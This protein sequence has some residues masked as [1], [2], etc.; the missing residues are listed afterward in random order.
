[1]NI[2]G[3]GHIAA[4][5]YNE[6][7]SVSGSGRID[8]SVR[9]VALSCS[10]SVR[11]EGDIACSEDVR[12]SGSSYF[13]KS[14]SA[15]DVLVSGSVSVDGDITVEKELRVSGGLKC[16]GSIKCSIMRCSGGIDVGKEA[17]ADEIRISGRITC[18]GLLNAEKIDISLDGVGSSSRIGSIGGSEI[19]VRN[20]RKGSCSPRMPL[21]SKLVGIGGGVLSVDELVEGDIVAVECVKAP[22]VVGRVVAIGAGCDIELVQYSEEIEIHPDAKVGR[23]EKI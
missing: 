11:G 1:M 5:E 9:C 12:V 6:K 4:G 8:G 2:S 19:K 20:D 16:G 15:K 3:S 21:L 13:K 14:V 18:T 23:Y 7:I 22:K 10:G 17:E